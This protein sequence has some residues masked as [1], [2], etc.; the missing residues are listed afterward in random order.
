MQCGIGTVCPSSW[1]ERLC[2]SSSPNPTHT[3]S[4]MSV[5]TI[6][7]SSVLSDENW[8]SRALLIHVHVHLCT[9]MVLVHAFMHVCAAI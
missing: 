1:E 3:T 7:I 5:Y 8:G 4:K 9:C 6:T 2:D